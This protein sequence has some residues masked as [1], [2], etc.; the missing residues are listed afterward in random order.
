[1]ARGRKRK[2]RITEGALEAARKKIKNQPKRNRWP[3]YED[4]IDKEDFIR[5][6]KN[7]SLVLTHPR[8]GTICFDKTVTLEYTNVIVNYL[9][10]IKFN[11]TSYDGGVKNLLD[12][13]CKASFE[14]YSEDVVAPKSIKA[15]CQRT[16]C[17]YY[18]KGFIETA[19]KEKLFEKEVSGEI[20][21]KHDAA[22]AK[23]EEEK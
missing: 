20:K 13:A 4:I 6:S 8:A 18:K 16:S 15:A 12:T 1:M 3:R 9:G 10:A 23:K 21:L 22:K 7:P 17:P 14:S 5:L 19:L 2:V 11:C